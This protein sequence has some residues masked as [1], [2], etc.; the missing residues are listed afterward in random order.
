M[1]IPHRILFFW[2]TRTRNSTSSGLIQTVKRNA[3]FILKV[4]SEIILT[5]SWCKCELMQS[6]TTYY[7]I[8][9]TIHQWTLI[10]NFKL[11]CSMTNSPNPEW[12]LMFASGEHSLHYKHTPAFV[13]NPLCS[14]Q[15]HCYIRFE[16]WKTLCSF[17]IDTAFFSSTLL[18]LR[19]F[20]SNVTCVRQQRQASA[21]R[22]EHKCRGR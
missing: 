12:G 13:S 6:P 17:W 14:F 2:L 11:S 16:N 19:T 15:T 21:S 7:R 5:C 3:R 18:C 8:I 1:K 4:K 9:Y 10:A 22:C 20:E